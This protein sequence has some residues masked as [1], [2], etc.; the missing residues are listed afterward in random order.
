MTPQQ[1][2]HST[3][4]RLSPD[5]SM[6]ETCKTAPAATSPRLKRRR[7]DLNHVNPGNEES[8]ALN[9]SGVAAPVPGNTLGVLHQLSSHLQTT[10]VPAITHH[11][12]LPCEAGAL[13]NGEAISPEW[14]ATIERAIKAIVSIRFSQVSAF[15][16]EPPLTSEASGFIVDAQRGI[17]LTNRHVVCA[18]PFTGEAI[19][20][21]HEEVEVYPIYRDPIH[22]F[23]FLRFDPSK[24]KYMTLQEISL[25]PEN[26]K[27]GLDIRVVGNDAGE[28]L[29][30]LSGSISRLDRN[31]PDYGDLTYN[32]FNTFYLQA[33][34]STS[35]GS[36]GSPVIDLHGNAVALQA[37]GS[38]H[39]ATDFFFPLDRVKHAL[40]HLQQGQ[41][42]PRGTIQTQFMYR[43]F[44]EV[45]RL[46]LNPTVEEHIRKLFP[47]SIGMLVAEVVL[48]KGPASSHLEEGDVLISINDQYVTQFVPLEAM[49]DT[50]LNQALRFRVDR[51]G[52]L[53]EFEIQVQ[54]LHSITPDRFVEIGGA[55]V[56]NLSYQLARSCCVPVQG[57]YVA[58]PF[59]M[60]RLNGSDQGWLIQSVDD[61]PTPTLDD[62]MRVAQQLPDRAL[63]KVVF[64]SI[65]NLHSTNVS[66]VQ[67][68]RHWSNFRL[69]V[70]NDATGLWD[71][72]EQPDAPVAP[73]R[74]PATAKFLQLDD[75]M[76][77]AKALVNS[78]VMVHYQ[79][80]IRVD[81]FPRHRRSGY[82]L[83]IDASRGLVVVSRAIVPH[84]LGDLTLTIAQ[85][86]VIPGTVKYIHPTQNFSVIAYDPS[87]LQ[88]T[89]V[90]SAPISDTPIGP[91][92]R[93]NLVAFNRH[94]RPLCLDTMVT[95]ITS[96][97]I[98]ES[99][100]PRFRSI[101]FEAIYLDTPV[102]QQC[103]SGVLADAQGR[104][105][106]L[107]LSFMGERNDD[108]DDREY[109]IGLG[110]Q[111]VM[112]VVEPM[113]RGE[114]PQLRLLDVELGPL[115]ISQ[116]RQ[117]GLSDDW[118]RR[119]EGANP[120]R[121]QLL[122]V[123]RTETGMQSAELLKDLDVVLAV[124]TRDAA[125][126]AAPVAESRIVTSV[127]DLA[128]Q[129]TQPELT[130]T[131]LRERRILNVT[132]PTTVVTEH[133][134]ATPDRVVVW[135][136]AV[137][138][139]PF[140][141][142]CQQSK[143]LPSR[144]YITARTKGSPAYMYDLVPTTWIT[145]IN[146]FPTPDL[147]AFIQAIRQCP[148][149]TYVRIKAITFD[150]IPM[151]LSLKT[152]HHY[153]P[154]AEL[155]RDPTTEIGWRSI[156]LT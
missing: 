93:V 153:W 17:I 156:K 91:G 98:P 44:D 135:S 83:V 75:S 102:A 85:S 2:I 31:V 141:A 122:M 92:H 56:H 82:G 66:V 79:M 99:S 43:P 19:A 105:Q 84:F 46:G 34:S 121:R 139:E 143:T 126:L 63:V 78:M 54:D 70:R 1:S 133:G 11:R 33:A 100:S 155:V 32:D 150:N 149:N 127:H 95:D 88:D 45:R 48:P 132:V 49:L 86:V 29:S 39:A 73:E 68:D 129:F 47:S 113:L 140:K 69:F 60:L 106:G 62:F 3:G 27:V 119:I 18:G 97:V 6:A 138:Q 5:I 23:G 76:G 80:P 61:Q 152:N 55:T 112:P 21:D 101:N 131:I 50:H 67:V 103:S 81:G 142:V 38:T 65:L 118:I 111:A 8:A 130:L 15:D 125:D 110:I 145:Q 137:V 134:D 109:Y 146:D 25:A 12:P 114:L 59:G 144:V 128:S 36:S 90:Q 10:H 96:V 57:V 147:E 22:D 120:Y 89:A 51:G 107:W 136:G 71:I 77:M 124:G 115:L 151:V 123:R 64:H 52:T 41:R 42:V 7:C 108:G 72:T 28:K 4:Q 35:G 13:T 154:A 14:Q 16:T 53:H 24:I 104:V 58:G 30:I 87:A 117:M 20:H 116:A 26:A 40:Q 94:Q 9:D 148:D 37:G 74:P